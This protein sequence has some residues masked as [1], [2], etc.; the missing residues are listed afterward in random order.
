MN[1]WQYDLVTYSLCWYDDM[2]LLCVAA[3]AAGGHGGGARQAGH[4]DRAERYHRGEYRA[5]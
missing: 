3:P 1:S 2:A 4:D 5:Y